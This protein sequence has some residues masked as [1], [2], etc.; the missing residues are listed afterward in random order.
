VGD[1]SSIAVFIRRI[2]KKIE[3]NPAKPHYIQTV[4]RAGYRFG[5]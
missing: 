1:T 3:E 2:R 4:W 5:D